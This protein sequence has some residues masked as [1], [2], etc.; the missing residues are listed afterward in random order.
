M[1]QKLQKRYIISS[2]QIVN[3]NHQLTGSTKSGFI[4]FINQA[5]LTNLCSDGS[6]L[7]KHSLKIQCKEHKML[8]E[9]RLAQMR[10]DVQPCE[11][12]MDHVTSVI[13]IMHMT[14]FLIIQ[15]HLL[16]AQCLPSPLYFQNIFTTPKEK[17]LW[18]KYLIP[19]PLSLAL[20]A[21]YLFSAFLSY[22]C[23]RFH[24]EETI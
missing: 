24:T 13:I 21:P 6:K 10:M 14:Y 12:S 9:K 1:L 4:V 22:L 19:F 8:H 3:I 2:L 15:W 20:A 17:H 18:I 11:I 7:L 5:R 23:W 16:H